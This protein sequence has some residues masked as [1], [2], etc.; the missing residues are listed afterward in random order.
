M[1][2]INRLIRSVRQGRFTER[3]DSNVATSY[4]K[5]VLSSINE[6]I[7]V[8]LLP[9]GEGNRILDQVAHGKVSTGAWRLKAA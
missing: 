3:A 8:I 2:D 6:L 4:L 7:N 5:E 9:I 1:D